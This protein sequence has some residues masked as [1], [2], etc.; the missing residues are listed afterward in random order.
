MKAIIQV[1]V[2]CSDDDEAERIATRA[3]EQRL[4][5]SVNIYPAISSAYY[6]DGRVNKRQEVPVVLKTRQELFTA[7]AELINAAHVYETPAILASLPDQVNPD[8]ADWVY[9]E[10]R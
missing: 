3:L 9:A 2:N 5:A 1:T 6:W 8:Y 7:L 4:A 10:T